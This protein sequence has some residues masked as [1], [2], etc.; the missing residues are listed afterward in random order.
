[1]NPFHR[2]LAQARL[3]RL[4]KSKTAATAFAEIYIGKYADF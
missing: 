1:V 4:L 3:R 2:R